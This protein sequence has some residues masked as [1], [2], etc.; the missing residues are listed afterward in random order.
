MPIT[1]NLKPQRNAIL[2]EFNNEFYC[3]LELTHASDNE[4]NNTK[5]SLNLSIVLDKSGSMSGEPLYEAKQAAIMMVNKMRSTD[6]ISVVAY[7]HSA[8]L[9]V[10]STSCENKNEIIN[11][12]QNI[13]E[14]GMTNLHNGWLMGAE[15]VAL[16]KDIKS[17]N[18]VLLLSDGNANEGIIDLRELKNHCSRLAET[19]IT[20]STYGL[21]SHFNE[22]LMIGMA[23]AGLGHSYY[24]QTSVD[25]MDP[26]NEEFE[27]LLNTVASELQVVSEHPNFVKLELMNNYNIMESNSNLLK[28]QMPDLAENGEAWAL[29]KIKIDQENVQND[30]L[31]VLRC[32][33]S[34]KNVNGEV[35]HKG[36]VKIVLDPVSQN[37][38]SQIAEDEK[39]RLRITEINIARFQERA[40]EA[41][42]SG[43][44]ALTDFFINEARREAKGNEWLNSVID[45]LEVYAKER[46]RENFSK[47][48]LYSSEKMNKR[49]VSKDE[50][51]MNYSIDLE[52]SKNAYL[53]RKV[54]RG[55]R[56]Q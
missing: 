24:G 34:Y 37:A 3:L 48:A 56:F 45:R 25:L 32:N 23:G 42:R 51:D 44:W 19:S 9:I 35:V 20:T 22:E 28:F 29:F 38:F 11:A 17:I 55:K 2:K 36:P 47:E 52:S 50:L 1:L 8:Q 46:Q 14:G 16:K 33:L 7:D 6:Q 26:F 21:G 49:L 15:Q 54:E 31:E 5:K 53:R 40:R 12:I 18:R 30:R 39:V 27:T 13:Y 10:P 43:D 41:A 4:Q